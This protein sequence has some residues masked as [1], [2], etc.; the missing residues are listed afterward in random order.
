MFSLEIQKKA[1]YWDSFRKKKISKHFHRKNSEY[2]KTKFFGFF[3][4]RTLPT[5]AFLYIS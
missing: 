1:F 5:Q 3:F 2:F 4:P